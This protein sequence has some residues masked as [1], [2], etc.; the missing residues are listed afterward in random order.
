MAFH[1][2][3]LRLWYG[4]A[5]LSQEELAGLSGIRR[6]A[7]SAFETA[8]E[9]PVVVQQLLATSLALRQPMER[10]IAPQVVARIRQEVDAR[11]AT[12]EQAPTEATVATA[13]RA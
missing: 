6:Q 10:L 13:A 7:V 5:G 4:D 11:R 8:T 12:F 1:H 2:R 3:R 9:L